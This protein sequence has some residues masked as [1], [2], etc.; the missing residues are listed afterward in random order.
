[1]YHFTCKYHR[2]KSHR[3]EVWH[4]LEQLVIII[5][6]RCASRC[7]LWDPTSLLLLTF[8]H[9]ETTFPISLLLQVPHPKFFAPRKHVGSEFPT[10]FMLRN[11]EEKRKKLERWKN[12]K[13]KLTETDLFVDDNYTIKWLWQWFTGGEMLRVAPF[14]SAC[15]RWC[16]RACQRLLSTSCSLLQ[17]VME[18]CGA[19]SITDLVKNTKGNTLKEDW[20]A[21]ISR[22]IL[23]VSPPF[24]PLACQF[25]ESNTLCVKYF[26]FGI[27]L[28]LLLQ[29]FSGVWGKRGQHYSVK[30][31]RFPKVSILFQD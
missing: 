11:K 25:H 23:R 16:V 30:Y 1:M 27:V 7:V 10:A 2:R 5:I 18:F 9:T 28:C 29:M 8:L 21:Y 6:I 12:A 13:H 26:Y 31:L 17:L 24:T 20:I 19:G 15:Q 3:S 4:D 22:E 14:F